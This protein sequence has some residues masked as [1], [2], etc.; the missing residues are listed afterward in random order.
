MLDVLAAERIAAV[1]AVQD[2]FVAVELHAHSRAGQR[3][4]V[5][6]EMAQQRLDL[7]PLD[8]GAD[9]IVE[10][11]ADQVVVLVAHF[12]VGKDADGPSLNLN[13]RTP[14]GEAR[15][16]QATQRRAKPPAA[17]RSAGR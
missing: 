4:D 12:E 11:V 10:D 14:A 3:L 6:A 13:V 9:G 8:V 1:R 15:R 7:A 16:P 17:Y 5:G 2:A